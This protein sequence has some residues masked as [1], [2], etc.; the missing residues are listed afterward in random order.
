[1]LPQEICNYNL[2]WWLAYTN[3]KYGVFSTTIFQLRGLMIAFY[4]SQANL[5]IAWNTDSSCSDMG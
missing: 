5:L 4:A 2:S 3:K 1:M